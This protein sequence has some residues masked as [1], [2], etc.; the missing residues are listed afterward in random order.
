MVLKS[1]ITGPESPIREDIYI[2][3]RKE[4]KRKETKPKKYLESNV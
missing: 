2:K 3:K 4:K 1:L